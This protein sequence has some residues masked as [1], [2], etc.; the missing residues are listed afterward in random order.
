M[1]FM[2]GL[3]TLKL[4]YRS[5][6]VEIQPE[7]T[8]S[9]IIESRYLT[10]LGIKQNQNKETKLCYVKENWVK[11]CRDFP[12]GAMFVTGENKVLYVYEPRKILKP[13]PIL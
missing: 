11:P 6:G 1:S 8:A 2:L 7:T 13:I 9:T 3:W 5:Y 10:A 4:Y 12:Q